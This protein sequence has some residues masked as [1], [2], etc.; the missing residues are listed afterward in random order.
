MEAVELP[1]AAMPR[2]RS[3]ERRTAM[4]FRQ[5]LAAGVRGKSFM[6]G[7]PPTIRC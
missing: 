1:Q 4:G 2:R 6:M 5:R 3:A 7:T